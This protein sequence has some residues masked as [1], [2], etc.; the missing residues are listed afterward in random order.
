M[1]SFTYLTSYDPGY[2]MQ[3]THF[4][5]SKAVLLRKAT[6]EYLSFNLGPD[7]RAALD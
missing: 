6:K 7:L 4:Q 1:V 5:G 2:W 3:Q